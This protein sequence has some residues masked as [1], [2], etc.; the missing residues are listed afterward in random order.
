MTD[1]HKILIVDDEPMNVK[2]FKAQLAKEGYDTY[3]A[4]SGEEALTLVPHLNPDLILLDIMMPGIDGYEVVRRLKRDEN[5][6]DI[7]IILITALDGLSDKVV[8][9]EAG[10]DEFLNK[11]VNTAE[12]KARV[13]SLLRLKQMQDQ[14][15]RQK[16]VGGIEVFWE[17]SGGLEPQLGL[18]QVLLVEDDE[19]DSRLIQSYLRGEPYG[20]KLIASG[21][22]AI[23]WA[24]QEKIDV[25]LLDILL[26]DID[27]LEVC[28]YLKEHEETRNIQILMITAV[29]D[30]EVK[31]R[32]I[33][34][35]ADDYLIKPINIHELRVCLKSLIRKKAY[36]DNLQANYTRAM[37]S[38]I[39]DRLTG[40]FNQAFFLYFLEKEVQ[41]AI[42]EEN[43]LTVIMIDVDHFK[44]YNDSKGHLAGDE[45]LQNLGRLIRQNI[46][47]IDLAARYGGDEFAVILPNIQPEQAQAVAERIM[48]SFVPPLS[49]DSGK[50]I[51]LSLGLATFPR[52]SLDSR[53]L[54]QCADQ[55]LYEAKRMGKNRTHTFTERPAVC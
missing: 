45:F 10:A 8:G 6:Q 4:S 46:R 51:T 50:R 33:E 41:R 32:G 35:G 28:R 48:N 34:L 16:S 21:V 54:L 22:E 12:L 13:K 43:S 44:D 53:Q 7:P 19:K 11:P 17:P 36:L 25:I 38:A 40:L 18:P 5:C 55:A 23:S 1:T 30:L 39:T 37:H 47:E 20:L 2:L 49:G 14:L 9:L 42:R 52:D 26:P 15:K 27:G 29:P 31:E 3:G 24:R